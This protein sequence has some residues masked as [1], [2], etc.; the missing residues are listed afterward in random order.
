MR[1]GD[2][3]GVKSEA[4]EAANG[5]ESSEKSKRVTFAPDVKPSSGPNTP[6][7]T[8]APETATAESAKEPK[9]DE[10]IDGVIGQLEIHQSGAVKMRLEN[11][12]LLDV[13]LRTCDSFHSSPLF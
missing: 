8:P 4:I 6:A 12:I 3:A 5:I 13:S 7:A 9:P 10:R 11:G 2:I 1:S